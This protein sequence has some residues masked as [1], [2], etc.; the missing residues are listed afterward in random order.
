MITVIR[1]AIV[2]ALVLFALLRPQ[3][4]VTLFTDPQ[5][6]ISAKCTFGIHHEY[7]YGNAIEGDH[8]DPLVR[9]VTDRKAYRLHYDSRE[10]TCVIWVRVIQP[11]RIGHGADMPE[12]GFGELQAHLT[13][14]EGDEMP[15]RS[16][17]NLQH[18]QPFSKGPG[19]FFEGWK[20]PGQISEYHGSSLEILTREGL[21]LAKFKVR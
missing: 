20:L 16:N 8:L 15:L 19:L 4:L 7:Y 5:F 9:L 10:P 17:G 14:E 12:G 13:T 6:Q 2:G 1:L 11:K 21:E 18:Y 3:P